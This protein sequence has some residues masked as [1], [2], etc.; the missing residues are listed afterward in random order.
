MT[1]PLW[2][3]KFIV[4]AVEGAVAAI[5][6]LALVIPT[7]VPEATAQAAIVGVAVLGAIV[8]AVRRNAG[9]ALLWFREKLQVPPED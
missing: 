8:A 7:T 2:V 4:D 3:R 1:L 9:A 5:L 6:V